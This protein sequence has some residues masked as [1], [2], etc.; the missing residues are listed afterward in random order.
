MEE[1]DEI[2]AQVMGAVIE[3]HRI[4]RSGLLES[5]YEEVLAVERLSLCPLWQDPVT[6]RIY[7]RNNGGSLRLT[8]PTRL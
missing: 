7:R 5:N 6:E 1:E 4:L 2:T 3:V 8:D